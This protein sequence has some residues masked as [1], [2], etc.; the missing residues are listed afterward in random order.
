M[1]E[2]FESKSS[3]GS[4]SFKPLS[5]GIGLGNLE[6]KLKSETLIREDPPPEIPDPQLNKDLADFDREK[7]ASFAKRL[8]LPW[9]FQ[10]LAHA[11]DF[12]I[13]VL[14]CTSIMLLMSLMNTGFR[15]EGLGVWVT[16][17]KISQAMLFV[18]GIYLLYVLLFKFVV[19]R[20]LGF[21]LVGKRQRD[22]F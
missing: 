18:Y 13:A 11:I 4:F 3:S 20:T 14:F 17:E 10:L 6:P 15:L 22:P 5:H 12:I 16:K 19:G 2:N 7:R 1:E 9:R 8:S 21:V